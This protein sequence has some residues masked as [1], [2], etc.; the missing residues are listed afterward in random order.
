[1]GRGGGVCGRGGNI[2]T[3]HEIHIIDP[4]RAMIY[5]NSMP[6]PEHIPALLLEEPVLSSANPALQW[7]S[8]TSNEPCQCTP[9][10]RRGPD[11]S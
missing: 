10:Q 1:M 8:K 6:Q 11:P 7:S 2:S 4:Q 3:S 9:E 5:F